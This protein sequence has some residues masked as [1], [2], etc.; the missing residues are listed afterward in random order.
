MLF[1]ELING[2]QGILFDFNGT[3]SD[4]EAVLEQAYDATLVH[5]GLDGLDEGEYASLLGRS[6][7][8]IARAVLDAR[9]EDGRLE[10]F[11]DALAKI[12]PAASIAAG[13][14]KPQAF[15]FIK[16]LLGQGKKVGIVTGTLR[17]MI[18]PLLAQHG[19]VDELDC[20]VT[21]EDVQVGKPDPE[22]F[23]LGAK[24][25]GLDTSCIVVFEDS[26]AG[27]AAADALGMPVVGVGDAIDKAGLAAHYATI[28]DAAA[29][30]LGYED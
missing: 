24:F 28:V 25:L 7:P 11:L 12:Y 20:L 1:K 14:L 18:V 17:S 26:N 16:W 22:G 15:E 29:E 10:E 3:L 19:V 27:F 30:V 23:A 13:C 4:D 6:D 2:S 9:G 8:D 21:I 5:L